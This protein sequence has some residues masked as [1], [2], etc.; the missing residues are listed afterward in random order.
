[1][2]QH[3]VEDEVVILLQ[4]RDVLPG[5]QARVDRAEIGHR[6]TA[7]RT[8]GVERQQ[9]DHAERIGQV[10]LEERSQRLQRRL[11]GR[12]DRIPVGDQYGIALRPQRTG[13]GALAQLLVRL[14]NTED[15]VRRSGAGIPA[16]EQ[17]QSV[18]NPLS[19]IDDAIS[20]YC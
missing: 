5:A 8:P 3:Q 9:V 7:V 4:R 10:T 20:L 11:L 14:H 19:R 18:A 17:D 2:V 13:H 6:E 15:A 12:L 1:M 16:V